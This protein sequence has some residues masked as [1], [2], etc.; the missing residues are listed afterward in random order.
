VKPDDARGLLHQVADLLADLLDERTALEP[1]RRG[2]TYRTACAL[3]SPSYRTDGAP[4][5]PDGMTAWVDVGAVVR[6]L[7]CSRSKGARISARSFGPPS[8]YWR[9][10]SRARR[11]LGSLGAEQPD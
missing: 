3:S 6:A 8:R 5:L 4:V 2:T 10:P 11:C 1:E 7:G 9:T